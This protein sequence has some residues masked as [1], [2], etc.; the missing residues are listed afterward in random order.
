MSQN[1]PERWYGQT[2]R[3]D[4]R[5]KQMWSLLSLRLCPLARVGSLRAVLS[6]SERQLQLR[7][8]H[9]LTQN[10]WP[11]GLEILSFK[12]VSNSVRLGATVLKLYHLKMW[13]WALAIR[14]S[15]SFLK[16]YSLQSR[17]VGKILEM[18]LFLKSHLK[19]CTFFM[20]YEIHDTGVCII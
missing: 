3:G 8:W 14:P 2:G 1:L 5:N 9:V 12:K 20:L 16:L 18:P 15:K 17:D 19:H 7:H 11:E 6:A 10:L 13:P 4:V